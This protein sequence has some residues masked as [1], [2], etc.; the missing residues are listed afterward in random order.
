[1]QCKQS[2]AFRYSIQ[3]TCSMFIIFYDIR[4]FVRFFFYVIFSFS[5]IKWYVSN[6]F[7]RIKLTSEW[8]ERIAKDGKKNIEERNRNFFFLYFIHNKSHY[9]NFYVL[10]LWHLILFDFFFLFYSSHIHWTLRLIYFYDP[11]FFYIFI[12]V[13]YYLLTKNT[14]MSYKNKKYNIFFFINWEKDV[15]TAVALNNILSIACYPFNNFINIFLVVLSK[16]LKQ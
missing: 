4:C 5:N 6:N 10:Y 3:Q 9:N 13:I 12:N 16:V 1:M 14:Y 8:F 15:V 2:N 7:E 11:I